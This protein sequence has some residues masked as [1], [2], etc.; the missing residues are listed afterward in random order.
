M[1]LE[2][3]SKPKRR[4]LPTRVL[5]LLI[6]TMILGPL[7]GF[8]GPAA[9]ARLHEIFAQEPTTETT[10]ASVESK[11]SWAGQVILAAQARLAEEAILAAQ[12]RLAT[13]TSSIAQE[14]SLVA[15]EAAISAPNTAIADR[16][17]SRSVEHNGG[18][19]T[20]YASR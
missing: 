12:A 16:G 18:N 6:A 10:R 8:C 9:H 5:S 7:L 4:L 3:P 19:E 1:V 11:A 14:V 20:R 2:T 17:R 15:Q 13:E